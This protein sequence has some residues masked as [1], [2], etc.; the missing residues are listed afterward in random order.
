MTLIMS[1]LWLGPWAVLSFKSCFFF[2]FS[3]GNRIGFC[4]LH[5]L[6]FVFCFLFLVFFFFFKVMGLVL[7]FF[8]GGVLS[9]NSI[10]LM[11]Y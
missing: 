10:R 6:F 2:F 9:N 1:Y 11:F 5:L 3:L 7:Y 4:I 8:V